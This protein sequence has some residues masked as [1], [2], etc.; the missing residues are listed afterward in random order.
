MKKLTTEE[1]IERAQELYPNYDFSKS[2]YTSA[3]AKVKITCLLHGEFLGT[4]DQLKRGSGCPTCGKL[5]AQKSRTQTTEKF[6]EKAKQIYG[7]LYDYSKTIYTK[8][9]EN[10]IIKCN[11]CNSIFEKNASSHI[12]NFI[13]C[14]KCSLK[15]AATR[16]T[17]TTKTFIEKAKKVHGEKYTYAK[18]DYKSGR[19]LV[20]I[21]CPEHGDFYQK[22]E[23]HLQGHGCKKCFLKKQ[24]KT[25]KEFIKQAKKIH[26][27]LYNYSNV[28][29]KNYQTE[30]KIKCNTCK[31]TFFQKPSSHLKGSG[32]PYCNF[33]KLE[34]CISKIL[35]SLEIQY[36]S[37]YSYPDCKFK[38]RLRF[39]F[40]LPNYN[41][42]I[43]AQGMQHYQ[44]VKYMPNGTCSYS[45]FLNSLKRDQIKREY[46]KKNSIPLLEL[47]YNE[48]NLFK[49]QIQDF[50]KL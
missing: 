31:K 27:D 36:I 24:T 35:D 14:P 48:T 18:V 41:I 26:K 5:K 38:K 13:G 3:T 6:I 11:T 8:A 22:P 30:V 33:S 40:Y 12:N 39:D 2:I 25:T 42:L 4:W 10:V 44:F 7:D 20:C 15:L 19:E 45:N 47:K 32:C 17:S 1:F 28:D 34:L 50:L 21:T 49:K 16:R 29:Y 37:Q 43:E 46:C 23:D 9:D